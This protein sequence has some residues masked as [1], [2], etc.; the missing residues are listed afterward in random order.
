MSPDTLEFG[1]PCS[2]THKFLV[3][4]TELKI[5]STSIG[6]IVLKSIISQEIF[7]VF[8]SIS[9]TSSA[10]IIDGP[11]P[12]IVKSFP[13]FLQMILLDQESKVQQVLL[14]RLRA[15]FYFQRLLMGS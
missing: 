12:T 11:K 15:K 3:F 9:D 8:S 7:F 13:D 1:Q 5:V 2:M 14:L 4:E 6:L 10:F